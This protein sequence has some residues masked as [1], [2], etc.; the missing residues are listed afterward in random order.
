MIQDS[1]TQEDI[2]AALTLHG[3]NFNGIL[4]DFYSRVIFGTLGGKLPFVFQPDQN[5]QDFA[6]C[7]LEKDSITFEQVA[8]EVFNVSLEI[9]EIW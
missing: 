2:L 8:P 4:D 1:V 3:R 9:Y 5:E 7:K 6:L